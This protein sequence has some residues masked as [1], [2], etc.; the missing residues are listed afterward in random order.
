[1]VVF[2]YQLVLVNHFVTVQTSNST[3]HKVNG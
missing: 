2:I 1:M 3:C